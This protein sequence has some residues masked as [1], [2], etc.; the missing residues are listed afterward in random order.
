MLEDKSVIM[1]NKNKSLPRY[2]LKNGEYK[3]IDYY[4]DS[5]RNEVEGEIEDKFYLNYSSN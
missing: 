1:Y 5:V 4:A 2:I 3:L